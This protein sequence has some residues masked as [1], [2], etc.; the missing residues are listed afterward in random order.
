MSPENVTIRAAYLE[1]R[2]SSKFTVKNKT[3]K[4]HHY[5]IMYYVKYLENRCLEDCTGETAC[6]F[7]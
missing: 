3:V 4:E 2:L 1:T 5:H 6:G 7:S